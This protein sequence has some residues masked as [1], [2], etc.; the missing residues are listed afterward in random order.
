[1]TD[2]ATAASTVE[3]NDAVFCLAHFKEVVRPII[4]SC[5]SIPS[6][7]DHVYYVCVKCTDCEVDLREEND[8]FF[9]VCIVSCLI[10]APTCHDPCR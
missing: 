5:S 2:V 3:I 8:G 4:L 7:P 1:M 10:R 9:G 6:H